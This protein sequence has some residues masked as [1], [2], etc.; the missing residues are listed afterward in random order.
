VVDILQRSEFFIGYQSGLNILADNL[1]TPQMM[2]YFD[3]LKP[4]LYTWCKKE[5]IK[6]KFF[7][8]VFSQ[9]PKDAIKLFDF[10][11]HLH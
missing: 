1:D 6:T 5:N 10:S 8:T 9:T 3:N 7:A 11:K 4:M 2:L